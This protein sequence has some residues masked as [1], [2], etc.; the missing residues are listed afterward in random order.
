MR[1]IITLCTDF[2]L[3]DH[4]QGAMK[5]VILGINPDAVIVDI[6]HSIPEFDVLSGAIT[7]NNFYSYFPPGTIH[8]G[9]VD[10][11]VG[12]ERKP[13]ALEADGHYFIGPDNGLFSLVYKR[14]GKLNVREI[15]NKEYMLPHVSSTFHGRDVF[16]PA[17]A[18]LSMGVDLNELGDEAASPL[19]LGLPVPEAEGGKVTG[20]V[21][22]GDSFGNLLT[23][24]PAEL[25]KRG[26]L[27]YVDGISLGIPRESYGSVK[28]GELLSIIGSSGYLE[29]AVCQGSALDTLGPDKKVVT[30]IT[31]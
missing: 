3:T 10:P 27:V 19:R 26:S 11:G 21:I 17:A 13:L 16:A 15:T 22:H 14:S 4:Y 31:E 30:V 12:G 25:V 2:G 29:I 28:K 7:L 9:V 24:I 1:R 23:N 18:H 6:T 5:G 8:I 20:E